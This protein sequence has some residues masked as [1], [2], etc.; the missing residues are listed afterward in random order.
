M[1]QA[2]KKM[3]P[4]QLF[5]FIVQAQIGVGVLSIPFDL[6]KTAKS[7]AG[8]SV[9]IAGVITQIIILM[10]WALL[11]RFPGMNLFQICLRLA[12]PMMGRFLIACY[13]GYFS[14]LGS[15]VLL[16]AYMVL[17]RWIL[18]S[19]PKWVVLILFCIMT[20]YLAKEKLT[21]LARFYSLSSM[22]FIPLIIFVSYG[23][24]QAKIE[25]M[26]PLAE[27]GLL[28]ILKGTKDTTISMYGFEMIL[29]IFP[30]IDASDSKKLKMISL[31]NL[32]VTLFYAF[33]VCT[34]L[35]VFNQTQ[36]AMIPE[37]VIYLVKSL[38]FYIIDRADILFLSIW[39]IT[40]VCSIASYSFAAADGLAILL[41][42]KNHH[43]FAPWINV[44]FFLIALLPTTPM[45]IDRI[46][47]VSEFAAYV[48]IAAIPF[49]LMLFTLF[50]KKKAGEAA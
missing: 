21:V 14:L 47:K 43:I 49:L 41:N 33:V 40:L 11:R 24:S 4:R 8:I 2:E 16:N 27:A 12:G 26:L 32:F 45:A 46:N 5:L 29:I 42:K 1:E 6:S 30:F 28:N 50:V 18:Q 31:S 10:M 9:L 22:L 20:Y 34:C 44:A 38:N 17:Q 37:P 23:L 7:G 35:M 13:V 36:L 15:N 19:T 48:F 39:S 3:S 25:Y